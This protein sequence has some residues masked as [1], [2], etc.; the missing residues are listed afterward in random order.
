M[1]LHF[2]FT[3]LARALQNRARE[4]DQGVENTV[5]RAALTTVSVAAI[6]TP[7]D[8]G[9]ARGNW[10]TRIGTPNEEQLSSP[11]S[12]SSVVAEGTG[13]IRQW[14]IDSPDIFITNN[15]EYIGF[16]DEGSSLQAPNGMTEQ[17]IAAGLRVLQ[18]IRVFRR[19]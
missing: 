3:S 4:I 1:A 11:R 19:P 7:V 6:A 8:T 10:R 5:R 15:I 18:Q 9:L 17:A 12:V 13:E 16:L 14:R 2:N